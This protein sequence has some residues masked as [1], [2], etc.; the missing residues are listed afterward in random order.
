MKSIMSSRKV[1]AA[2]MRAKPVS[3]GTEAIDTCPRLRSVCH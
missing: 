3:T 1:K 2:V